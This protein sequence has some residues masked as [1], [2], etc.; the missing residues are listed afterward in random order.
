[1]VRVLFLDVD[2]VINVPRGMDTRLL[3]NLRGIVEDTQCRIVLSSDWRNTAE[4]RNEIRRILRS[5]GMDYIACTPPSK[6]FPLWRRPMEI[7]EWLQKHNAQVE[8]GEG[9]AAEL[10]K[11]EEWV[12]ID[13]RPLLSEEGGQGLQGHF[14]QT[15]I[16]TGLTAQ[17]AQVAKSILLGRGG[18]GATPVSGTVTPAPTRASDALLGVQARQ[19]KPEVGSATRRFASAGGRLAGASHPLPGLRPNTRDRSSS[20]TGRPTLGASH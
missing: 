4:A 12:A 1:M 6:P 20:S 9:R 13:D 19:T 3:N 18:A 5:F 8:R 2:G 11:V 16:C 15:N 7:L 10:G 17:R 14:V